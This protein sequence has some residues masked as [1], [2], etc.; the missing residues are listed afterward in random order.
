MGK[1]VILPDCGDKSDFDKEV[2]GPRGA[3][4]LD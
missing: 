1:R 2:D 4:A 3:G